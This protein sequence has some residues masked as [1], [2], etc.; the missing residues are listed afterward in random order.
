MML[1]IPMKVRAQHQPTHMQ[2]PRSTQPFRVCENSVRLTGLLFCAVLA[3]CSTD[4]AQRWISTGAGLDWRTPWILF[5]WIY[6][7]GTYAAW[8]Y[9]SCTPWI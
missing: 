7:A 3:Y 2:P 1:L 9:F 6:V 8:V 4:V 5:A